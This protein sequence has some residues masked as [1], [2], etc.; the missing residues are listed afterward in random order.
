MK[1]P[2]IVD[3]VSKGE[4][5]VILSWRMNYLNTLMIDNNYS[6]GILLLLLARYNNFKNLGVSENSKILGSIIK[7][8]N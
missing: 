8:S 6:C 5:F 7:S 1:P 4:L 2:K 3:V